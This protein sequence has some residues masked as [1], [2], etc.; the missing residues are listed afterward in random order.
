M[1][2]LK[3]V[4]N[5]DLVDRVCYLLPKLTPEQITKKKK[6]EARAHIISR[7]V[8]HVNER[9]CKEN[10]IV[11]PEIPFMQDG[12]G[13]ANKIG[14]VFSIRKSCV[15]LFAKVPPIALIPFVKYG[16]QL[17]SCALCSVS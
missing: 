3:N 9:K 11:S 2:I 10:R 4:F 17:M 8:Y 12:L 13:Q 15:S 1:F 7:A 5:I 14:W 16:D 6:K